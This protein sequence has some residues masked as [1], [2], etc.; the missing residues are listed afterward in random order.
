M[1]PLRQ[2]ANVGRNLMK[3]KI[4][5]GLLFWAT[6]ISNCVFGQS[7]FPSKNEIKN[8]YANKVDSI[9]LLSRP[10]LTG[11]NKIFKGDTANLCFTVDYLFY[12]KDGKVYSKEIV[13]HCNNDCSNIEISVSKEIELADNS[14]FRV[15]LKNFNLIAIEEILPYTFKVYDSSSKSYIYQKMIGLHDP[16]CD[17]YI[18]IDKKVISK[19]VRLIDLE[20]SDNKGIPENVNYGFNNRTKLKELLEKLRNLSDCLDGQYKF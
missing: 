12:L 16:V 8:L 9:V 6:L 11:F 5:S 20:L 2:A 18:V 15:L 14:L 13:E 1:P 10:N 17:L 19:S 3:L 7:E 4:L